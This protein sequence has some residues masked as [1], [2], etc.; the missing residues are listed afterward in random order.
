[1]WLLA[2]EEEGSTDVALETFS[3]MSVHLLVSLPHLYF[4]SQ[5][6]PTTCLSP[7]RC[8]FVPLA[9]AR[10][11]SL[12]RN[13]HSGPMW[14][15]SFSSPKY[16]LGFTASLKSSLTFPSLLH[17]HESG[18]PLLL[19][20]LY[21]YAHFRGCVWHTAMSPPQQKAVGHGGK[22]EHSRRQLPSVKSFF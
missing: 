16:N 12:G 17:T 13:F 14:V 9:P 11:A 8:L 19:H 4:L 2:A 10:A 1:M 7:N 15:D 22:R 6:N 3:S 21:A 5:H 18:L 20:H